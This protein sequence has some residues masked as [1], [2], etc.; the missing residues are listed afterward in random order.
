MVNRSEC[1]DCDNQVDY[2]S[3]D[4]DL[5]CGDCGGDMKPVGKVGVVRGPGPGLMPM[6]DLRNALEELRDAE[7]GDG[8][9]GAE[10]EMA[11]TVRNAIVER[12]E[13]CIEARQIATGEDS[14]DVFAYVYQ[15]TDLRAVLTDPDEVVRYQEETPYSVGLTPTGEERMAGHVAASAKDGGEDD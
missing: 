11:T 4:G 10:A 6:G 8:Y 12:L 13:D 3:R 5:A 14:P 9:E 2:L 1:E 7:Y 15:A